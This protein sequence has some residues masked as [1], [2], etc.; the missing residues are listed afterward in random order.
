M[1]WFE[2]LKLDII[3]AHCGGT[4][5]FIADSLNRMPDEEG[6]Y[7]V[8]SAFGKETPIT[9]KEMKKFLQGTG[10]RGHCEYKMVLWHEPSRKKSTV[11]YGW[12]PAHGNG[13]RL[14]KRLHKRVRAA[15][16][17]SHRGNTPFLHPDVMEAEAEIDEGGDEPKT[18]RDYQ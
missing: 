1:N 3:K 9:A 17:L 6:K 4:N 10:K 15:F 18:W 12:K 5:S 11:F 8:I 14:D 13:A 16:T 7:Q 2:I